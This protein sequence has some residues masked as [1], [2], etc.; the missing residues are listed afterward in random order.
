MEIRKLLEQVREGTMTLEEA[1]LF[2]SRLPYEELDFAKLD[3]HRASRRGFG[4]TVFCQGKTPEQCAEI[5]ARFYE[6]DE[7][8][9]GTRAQPEHFQAIQQRLPQASYS[10]E[11]KVVSLCPHPMKQQGCVAV[12]TAGTSDIPA[13]EE[14]ALTAEFFGAKTLRIF[15]VGVAGIHRLFARMEDIHQAN[16]VIACAGMEGA[17]ASVIGGLCQVP[18]IALPT[19]VGYGSS[20]GGLS[21]LLTMLNSC[22]EGVGTV[23]IDNGFGAGY[24]A[25]QINQLAVEGGKA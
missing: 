17:L 7:N 2:L 22:A 9:L 20:F 10:P 12:C 19:S 14:A 5:F 8:I 18:V 4:E 25:A 21:A 11:A 23:N 3:H 1:E 24:L 13:A 16:A 15:D 6:A